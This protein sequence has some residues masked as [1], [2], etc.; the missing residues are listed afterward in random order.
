MTTHRLSLRE[1]LKIWQS[2]H[3]GVAIL[4]PVTVFIPVLAA[5]GV[6]PTGPSTRVTGRVQSV[7]W[8][9]SRAR[10]RNNVLVDVGG[11]I[12]Q[13]GIRATQH[14]APRDLIELRR[15]PHLWGAS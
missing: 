6:T 7:F 1:T 15:L 5:V 9:A 10:N 8:T 14:C 2:F 12:V 3:P 4:I 11:Q 13:T